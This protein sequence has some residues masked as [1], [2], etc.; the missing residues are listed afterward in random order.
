MKKIDDVEVDR[1]QFLTRETILRDS[2]LQTTTQLNALRTV[3]ENEIQAL[4]PLL[5][6]QLETVRED[7]REMAS[8]RTDVNLSADRFAVT[9]GYAAQLESEL[10]EARKSNERLEMRMK[11]FDDKYAAL[12]REN[13]RLERLSKVTLAA[14]LHGDDQYREMSLSLKMKTRELDEASSHISDNHKEIAAKKSRIAELEKALSESKAETEKYHM[15]TQAGHAEVAAQEVILTELRE[16]LEE[17]QSMG[18]TPEK[19]EEMES[20]DR[21]ISELQDLNKKTKKQLKMSMT[22]VYELQ[23]EVDHLRLGSVTPAG[24]GGGDGSGVEKT[25]GGEEG[26]ENVPPLIE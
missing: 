3:Y 21:I 2:L 13:G 17:M 26:T 11:A 23:E 6:E 16:K 15:K 25:E 18:C 7:R 8:L 12:M 5:F 4:R 20:K 9:K 19:Q 14:K 22:R 10:E 24:S 1:R